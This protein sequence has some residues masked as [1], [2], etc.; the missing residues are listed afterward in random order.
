[1]APLSPEIPKDHPLSL[2][3]SFWDGF[4][5]AIQMGIVDQFVTPLALFLGAGSVWIG[6]LNFVRNSF[7]SIVQIY[8]SF[9]TQRLGSRKR[10]IMICV[11][12]AALLWLPTYLIP[13]LFVELRVPVFILLFTLTSSVNMLA[14]PAWASLVSEY[15]PAN[16]RGEYFGWRGTTL[17]LVYSAAVLCAGLL[18]H[19]FHGPGLFWG[20]FLL[21]AAAAVAR[22]LSWVFISRLYEPA[23]QV[24][25]T[26][27]FTFLQ[28]IGRLPVSN[29]AKYSVLAAMFNFFVALVSPFFA[30]YLLRD[31][32]YDYFSFT[33]VIGAS[34]FTTL[35]FQQYW[36]GFADRYGNRKIF[37]LNAVLIAVVPLL[38]LFSR[39][40][41][42]LIVIQLLAGIVW[43]GFNLATANFIYDA[44]VSAKRERCVSYYNFLSGIGLGLGALIGGYLYH[45]LPALF[46]HSFYLLLLLSAAGRIFTAVLIRYN[47]KEV[48]PVE[49]VRR[50]MLLYDVS[51]LRVM[52]LLTRE[53]LFR[54]K[55]PGSENKGQA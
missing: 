42:Y 47:V 20:F 4:F 53:L 41:W 35:V 7:V 39:R 50:R 5:A 27:S 1:M 48:R 21:M 34:V 31:L 45:H 51:G 25:K 30:V 13:F 24:K 18:L 2:K 9:V 14:T 23:W 28:F 6:V 40:M 22:F 16:K 37:L 12:A 33:L 36:G 55:Q 38:W 3:Y 46:G 32:G 26:D 49:P 29:F 8:S 52:G 10:F 17:G 44:V 43:A 19:F 11:L 15:I 54:Q